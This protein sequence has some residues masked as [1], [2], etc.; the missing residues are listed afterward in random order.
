MLTNPSII[1]K[2]IIILAT[3]RYTTVHR[4][5]R[6]SF[7]CLLLNH[8]EMFSLIFPFSLIVW[9][10]LDTL[11]YKLVLD[12]INFL[13]KYWLFCT[14]VFEC[15]IMYAESSWIALGI[16]EVLKFDDDQFFSLLWHRSVG[17][18]LVAGKPVNILL[19]IVYLKY[20]SEQIP[21]W[22]RP[23]WLSG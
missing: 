1:F 3:N 15:W 9:R 5:I 6:R 2:V 18:A 17:D 7:V 20:W 4:I 11:K 13:W 23:Q 14:W 12:E 8:L 21:A 10:E 22:Y 19:S 16:L